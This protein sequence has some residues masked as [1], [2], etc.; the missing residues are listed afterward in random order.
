[1][2]QTETANYALLI[3]SDLHLSEGWHEQIKRV[4]RHEDFFFDTNFERFLNYLVQEAKERNITYKLVINGDFVDFLQVVRTD[5]L[6]GKKE[7]NGEKLTREEKEFGL[8]TSPAKTIWKLNILLKGHQIFFTN[9]A[10]F[11][12]LGHQLIIV[13]GNH[14]IEWI[15]PEVQLLNETELKGEKQVS[16]KIQENIVFSPWF[17]YDSNLS[18]Y[19]EHGCQYDELN[20]FDYFL[21]PYFPDKKHIYLPAGSFFVRY[22]FNKVESSFPFAD[23][24]KP[25]S[26]FIRWS[27][28]R[29]ETWMQM[30]KYIRFFRKTLNKARPIDPKWATTLWEEQEREVENFSTHYKIPVDTLH[31]IKDMWVPSA[32]HHDIKRVLTWKFFIHSKPDGFK[33]WYQYLRHRAKTIHSCL[34][35]RYIIFGHTH[36]PDIFQLSDK[37]EYINSG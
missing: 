8:G 25:M 5:L 7:I 11:L 30:E 18:A 6:R 34:P 19:I 17:F 32:L 33:D 10:R 29:L 22:L 1:V 16:T 4:S 36:E 27:L 28:W 37:A 26:R 9:L 21:Y 2:R 23:N 31:K 13:A 3:I 14:D 12:A 24:I 35:V 20:S 15:M